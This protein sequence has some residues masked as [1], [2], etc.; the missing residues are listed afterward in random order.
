[1]RVRHG[2]W[3]LVSDGEKYLILENMGS[4]DR[5]ALKVLQTE[6][7]DNPPNREQ[8]ADRP[9]RY[10]DPGGGKSAVEETDWHKLEK[11]RFAETLAGRLRIWA[12]QDR[13]K[14]LILVCDPATLGA[15]RPKLHSDLS[16]RIVTE[17]PKDLTGHPV[18][19][20]EK[21]LKEA[22]EPV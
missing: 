19:R 16:R 2:T 7:L 17:F 18:S 22:S 15:I 4:A 11:V 3:V 14:H 12:Q 20:I 21:I 9:G 6:A 8:A 5:P 10:P 1:M 13:F